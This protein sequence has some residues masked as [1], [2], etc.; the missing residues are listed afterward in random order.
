MEEVNPVTV[1][2]VEALL[3]F[4]ILYAGLVWWLEE[5]HIGK[6]YT[7]LLV[8]IGVGATIGAYGLQHGQSA[9]LELLGY[10]AASG[11]PMILACSIHHEKR[12]SDDQRNSERNAR[13]E[14]R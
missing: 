2:F 4:G 11:G 5:K 1:S 10:F 14:L 3:I 13:Q 12:Q 7:W 6:A 9:F 8:A